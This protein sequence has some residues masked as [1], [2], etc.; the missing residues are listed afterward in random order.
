MN[1]RNEN[2]N[3]IA[4]AMINWLRSEDLGSKGK[5][6]LEEYKNL[7]RNYRD[8]AE[9][10]SYQRRIIKGDFDYYIELQAL[11][12]D[13]GPDNKELADEYFRHYYYIHPTYS[14][15]DCTGKPFTEWYTLVYRDHR[16]WAYHCVGF[17]V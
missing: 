9:I 2:D 12:S 17:D 14:M 4:W 6:R 5:Q 15:Y 16:W 8:R 1:I 3:R 13:I 11:S 10:E 7:V